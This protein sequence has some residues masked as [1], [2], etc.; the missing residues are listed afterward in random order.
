MNKPIKKAATIRKGKKLPFHRGNPTSSHLEDMRRM[1][2]FKKNINKWS[3]KKED[4]SG[5]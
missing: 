3:D 2:E 4:K 1:E 5:T